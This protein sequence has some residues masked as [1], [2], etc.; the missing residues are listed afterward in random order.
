MNALNNIEVCYK[1]K[2]VC[3]CILLTK[4]ELDVI[5]RGNCVAPFAFMWCRV[6]P[7]T[8]WQVSE[9]AREKDI[10]PCVAHIWGHITAHFLGMKLL[11]CYN[12]QTSQNKHTNMV[13]LRIAKC[14]HNTI[15]WRHP[16]YAIFGS[17]GT[18]RKL[19]ENCAKDRCL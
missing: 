11:L 14:P 6:C 1:T 2:T 4:K 19:G 5:K 16:G 9:S 13:Y 3:C 17:G 10:W 15:K 8:V 12:M 18:L 7:W